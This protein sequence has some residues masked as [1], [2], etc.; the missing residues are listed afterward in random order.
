MRF[1]CAQSLRT[2]VPTHTIDVTS[3]ATSTA[4][5]L[6]DVIGMPARVAGQNQPKR[7]AVLTAS[8]LLVAPSFACADTR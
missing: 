1:V 4:G 3:P 8:A 2:A 5:S 7:A 6:R